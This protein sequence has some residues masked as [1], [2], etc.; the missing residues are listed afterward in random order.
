MLPQ[1]NRLSSSLALNTSSKPDRFHALSQTLWCRRGGWGGVLDSLSALPPHGLPFSHPSIMSPGTSV[2]VS[3]GCPQSSL[4]IALAP[5]TCVDGTATHH[6]PQSVAGTPSS[7]L[8]Q[9][10]KKKK[11]KKRH[12]RGT[13][14]AA[15]SVTHRRTPTRS[16]ERLQRHLWGR[17]GGIRKGRDG[18]A[19][20]W[21]CTTF[22][23]CRRRM[24]TSGGGC[25]M[26]TISKTK[27]T[28]RR[29]LSRWC[30]AA[31]CTRE[32]AH[33]GTRPNRWWSGKCSIL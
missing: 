20:N 12:T 11:K 29:S 13:V 19:T 18:A 17:V 9:G 1:E 33:H 14:R 22:Q 2:S 25:T 32:K 27:S 15:R 16:L 30:V 5:A 4:G 6:R 26:R 3:V 7:R 8:G 21:Q 10:L 31:S 24:R 23:G 28:P